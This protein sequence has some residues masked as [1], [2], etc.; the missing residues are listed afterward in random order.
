ME[1]EGAVL[2]RNGRREFKIGA[3]V[4][5]LRGKA[6]HDK[7]PDDLPVLSSSNLGVRGIQQEAPGD[8][9][10][11]QGKEAVE[12]RCILTQAS[13]THLPVFE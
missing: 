6:L 5:S 7:C 2:A 11:G 4:G 3:P 12:L 1:R 9:Q 10:V 13:V 8:D